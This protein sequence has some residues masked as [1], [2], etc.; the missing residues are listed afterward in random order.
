[1]T[2]K[3][4][5]RK[6]TRRRIQTKLVAALGPWLLR[7]IGKS[8]RVI[9]LDPP[10]DSETAV[11][12]SSLAPIYSCWHENIPAAAY[13]NRDRD[14]ALLV[15]Q[16]RDGQMIS[17]VLESMGYSTVRGSS[18][19]GGV[20]ALRQLMRIGASE[21]GLVVTPDGPRGPA[22]SVAS[23]VL[24]LAATSGRPILASGLAATRQWRA[25]SWDRMILPKIFAKVVI[26]YAEPFF[27]PRSIVKDPEQLKQWANKLALHMDRAHALAQAG[28]RS[29]QYKS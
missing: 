22:H 12:A 17:S 28:L 27:V 13:I 18:S 11:P 8:W 25:G 10:I 1:V 26:A 9:Q 29:S 7:G 24:Y 14:L 4:Q 5:T 2:E 19:T 21:Q 23:G 3:K 16:H 6:R 20:A 15:S